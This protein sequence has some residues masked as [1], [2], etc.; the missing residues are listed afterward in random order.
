MGGVD[1]D[2]CLRL[3]GRTGRSYPAY[4]NKETAGEYGEV[5]SKKTLRERNAIK[6]ICL[7]CKY[8]ECEL[9]IPSKLGRPRKVAVA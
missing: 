3:K 7:E 8:P 2:L 9:A 5:R 1:N 4:V 6:R